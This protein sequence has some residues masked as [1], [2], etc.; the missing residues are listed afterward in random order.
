MK[1]GVF[2]YSPAVTKGL[3]KLLIFFNWAH[4]NA[5]WVYT[6][7]CKRIL[8]QTG[9]AL[10]VVLYRVHTKHFKHFSRTFQGPHQIFKEHPLGI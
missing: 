4:T 9:F 10:L 6:D 5:A 7:I 2:R 3:I 8:S 1:N